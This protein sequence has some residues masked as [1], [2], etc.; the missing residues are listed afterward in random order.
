M[1]AMSQVAV[2]V[3]LLVIAGC[4]A[5]VPVAAQQADRRGDALHWLAGAAIFAGLAAL[6]VGNLED[7]LRDGVRGWAQ[8]S[9]SYAERAEWQLPVVL[10]AV[11]AGLA[12]LLLFTRLHPK[13]RPGS[14]A[15]L[16]LYSR[17]ALLALVPLYGLR[18][19]SLH[20]VDR[21]LYEGPLRINWLLEGAVWLTVGVCA[22]FYAMRKRSRGK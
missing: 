14:R 17:F 4:L 1:S 7:R 9:G 5:A 18:L 21:V 3:Y 10:A 8:V 15:R 16:V 19:V 6:R 11:L 20:Q 13:M 2:F 12:I 22:T